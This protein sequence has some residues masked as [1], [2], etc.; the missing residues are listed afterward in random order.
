MTQRTTITFYGRRHDSVAREA[1]HHITVDGEIS[2]GD[3][4]RNLWRVGWLASRITK[5]TPY[6]TLPSKPRPTNP[7]IRLR[8]KISELPRERIEKI[9]RETDP[10]AQ[11]SLYRIP[12]LR[13]KAAA[14]AYRNQHIAMRF[15]AELE[16]WRAT[17]TRA[18]G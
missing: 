18:H 10:S 17:R 9:I 4:K 13:D 6:T 15:D 11:P 3:A 1:E 14:L 8:Q 7:L 12:T 2:L 5:V 16:S